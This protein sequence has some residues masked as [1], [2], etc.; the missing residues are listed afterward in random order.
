MQ[1]AQDGAGIEQVMQLR[2]GVESEMLRRELASIYRSDLSLLCSTAEIEM[3]ENDYDIPPY[4]AGLASFWYPPP[5]ERECMPGFPNRAHFCTIGTYRHPPNAD[6][7]RWL[8]EEIWP[9]LK[10][11]LPEAEMH[12]YGS[13][14]DKGTSRLSQPEHGFHVRGPMAELSALQGYRVLLAPLRFG[15]GIKGK[16]LDAWM[17]GLPVV[18]TPVGSEGLDADDGAPW[19]G[20]GGATT[21]DEVVAH[22]V[23]LYR[24]AELWGEAQEAGYETMGRFFD[25]ERNAGALNSLLAGAWE[26]R[27]ATRSKDLVGALLWH[28]TARSTEFFSRWIELK[29]SNTGVAG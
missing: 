18:T 21:A 27:E 28:H 10:A 20:A 4:K 5:P 25:G 7:V 22:A 11:E 17:N 12:C 6:A 24:N 14:L 2:P 29:N 16:V 3:L 19:G 9:R 1:L 15:A 13:Y 26:A 8:A 23:E